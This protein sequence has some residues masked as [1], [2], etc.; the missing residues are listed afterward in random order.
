MHRL[1][2]LALLPLSAAP[3]P[4]RLL[5]NADSRN[6]AFTG[7]GRLNSELV[8]TAFAVQPRGDADGPVYALTNGHCVFEPNTNRVVLNAPVPRDSK[9]TF[10]YFADTETRQVT[11]PV[12]SIPYATMKGLDI[13]VLELDA[14]WAAL[15]AAGIRPIPLAGLPARRG[16][17]VFTVGAPLSGLPESQA[18]LRRS[19]CPVEA[20]A[21]V[22]EG[23]W[24]FHDAL[25]LSCGGIFGGASGSPVFDARSGE[26]VAI[27]NT[28]TQGHIYSS[29]DI[30]CFT[31]SP[32]ELTSQSGT[33]ILDAAYALP[34]AGVGH[35]FDSASRFDLGQPRC[36][37]DP[38][39]E[40]GI[41]NATF[42]SLRPG[43]LWNVQLSANGFAGYRYKSGPEASTNCRDAAGYSDPVS[44]AGNSGFREPVGTSDGRYVL[45]VWG[46]SGERV[47]QVRHA[48]FVHT[49]IDTRPPVLAP[50]WLVRG[51]RDS[52]SV[53]M[54]FLVPDLSDYRYKFGPE[55]QTDCDNMDG[56]QIYRRIP[57][58]VPAAT[59]PLIRFCI[60]AGD[61]TDNF[62]RPT[63]L[64]LGENQPLPGG[65]VNSGGFEPGPVSPGM[66]VSVFFAS[67]FSGAPPFRLQ[68]AAGREH[69]VGAAVAGQQVNLYIP[70]DAALGPAQLRI[71]GPLP[72]TLLMDVKPVAPGI[73]TGPTREASG[74][75]FTGSTGVLIGRCGA[76]FCL[77]DGLVPVPSEVSLSV[78]GLLA[79]A[80]TDVTVWLAGQRLTGRANAFGIRF[81]LPANFAYR[82]Q[83]PIQIEVGGV[84]SNVAY[85]FLKDEGI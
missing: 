78:N 2:L 19:D 64:L 73:F 13:A 39:I 40:L 72:S 63:Q 67:P 70:R 66:W 80:G 27:I 11:V 8:C 17:P 5:L 10:H 3:T 56:Y 21:Q 60:I 20:V 50:R 84:R 36:P 44:F 22:A 23:M 79:A 29:G 55:R 26:A 61:R 7:V 74:F 32:C 65:L 35:C 71:P 38:G 62:T 46:A 42:P 69:D 76:E 1:L 49:G 68:D 16:D 25:R 28:S 45:C 34:L 77:S 47:Q 82:G 58:R 43:A 81:Q 24:K 51:D 31:N 48:S 4:S 57:I 37:L 85:L 52:Y 14:N 30:P 9:V 12:R 53:Q 41:A 75:F 6:S 33:M 59:A 18:W 83:V 54:V 15:M